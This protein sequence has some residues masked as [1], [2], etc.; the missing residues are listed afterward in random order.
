MRNRSATRVKTALIIIDLQRGFKVSP[1]L[2]A[3]I[4]RRRKHPAFHFTVFTQ[5]VNPANSLYRRELG[6]GK[7]GPD[8]PETELL[9]T[10]KK[11]DWPY[12]KST[13]G[14]PAALIRKLRRHGI[15]H[16]E[17]CGVDT[18]ACVLAAMFTLFD[19]GFVVSV[20]A[21]LTASSGRLKRSARSIMIR[22]F[23]SQSYRERRLPA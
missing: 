18:D 21:A 3:R 5:F 11:S 15:T 7:M 14:L 23:G 9:L 1:R 6:Y 22:Q 10:P 2:V 17:L 20:D 13:Y 19:A 16:V 4:A 12:I 8:S